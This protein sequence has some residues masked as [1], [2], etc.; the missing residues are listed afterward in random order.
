MSIFILVKKI[1]PELSMENK[2]QLNYVVQFSKQSEVTNVTSL[3]YE[4][5][6]LFLKNHFHN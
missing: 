1:E 6:R 5:R 4:L 3:L 2:Y